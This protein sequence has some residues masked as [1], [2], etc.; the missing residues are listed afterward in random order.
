VKYKSVPEIEADTSPEAIASALAEAATS[1]EPEE[2]RRGIS[3]VGPHRDEVVFTIDGLAVR[4]YASQGQ[5]KTLL[6][7]LKIAEVEHHRST[8]EDAP[9]LLLDD[10]LGDLDQARSERMIA[11]ISGLGQSIITATADTALRD[12]VSWNSH[13]RRFTV[14]KGTCKPC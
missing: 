5:Q 2:L 10:L 4:P 7:A 11:H 13:N 14:E 9:I 3:L 6:V 12:F 8:G 1:W